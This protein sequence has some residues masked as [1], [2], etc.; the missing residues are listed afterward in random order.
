MDKSLQA[1]S[2]RTIPAIG[3]YNPCDFIIMVYDKIISKEKEVYVMELKIIKQYSD[4]QI[5]PYS[6]TGPPDFEVFL[7]E[8]PIYIG[9]VNH[10]TFLQRVKNC[11]DPGKMFGLYTSIE[12]AEKD[13][14]KWGI[15]LILHGNKK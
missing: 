11:D 1:I 9:W 13:S 5:K 12:D 15:R 8:K 7:L 6:Y 10:Y 3:H 2:R 4:D 14:Q